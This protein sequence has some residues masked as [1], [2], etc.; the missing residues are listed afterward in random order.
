M[1]TA[2]LKIL[3]TT[4]ISVTNMIVVHATFEA[5]SLDVEGGTEN[6]SNPLEYTKFVDSY[7]IT[8]N[9]KDPWKIHSA[10]ISPSGAWAVMFSPEQA[11]GCGHASDANTEFFPV[12]LSGEISKGGGGSGKMP[13]FSVCGMLIA[14]FTLER[15]LE[16]VAVG[17]TSEFTVKDSSGSVIPNVQW[18]CYLQG[19]EV[20][21][22]TSGSGTITLPPTGTTEAGVYI[23]DAKPIQYSDLEKQS[24]DLKYVEIYSL[25]YERPSGTW[26]DINGDIYVLKG[27]SLSFKA[28][29][30]PT[31]GWPKD[32]PVWSGTSGASGTGETK[33]VSFGTTSTSTTDYKTVV[34]T[35]G[36]STKTANVIVFDA[37]IISVKFTSDHGV[38]KD[39]TDTCEDGGT[40]YTEPEWVKSSSKNNPISQTKGTKIA[41]KVTV[42][43]EPSGVKYNLTGSNTSS[44]FSFA[45][46]NITST[47]NNQESAIEANAELPNKVDI[48]TKS[49]NWKVTVE[50]IE[51]DLGNTGGHKVYVTYGIPAGSQATE[52]RI[53]KV[54][55]YAS[56]KTSLSDCGNAIFDELS[57]SFTYQGDT[58]WGPS[59]IWKLYL[60]GQQNTS[61]CPGLADFINKHFQILGLGAGIIKICYSTTGLPLD[62][63]TGGTYTEKVYTPTTVHASPWRYNST[64]KNDHTTS[65]YHDMFILNEELIHL[66]NKDDPTGQLNNVIIGINKECY[67]VRLY[68][69]KNEP[70]LIEIFYVN[71]K[72][73]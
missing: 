66:L 35:C 13:E 34:A 51:I 36:T 27:E 23:V 12:V 49:I 57:G 17:E 21:G 28:F 3:V 37:E 46:D 47:G 55:T 73:Y 32:K 15:T 44:Y 11:D 5:N 68:E 42:K 70:L 45:K 58:A 67:G 4:M 26:N 61:Q 43:V 60:G 19:T 20:P 2:A 71:Y 65:D 6:S 48:I 25:K 63:T 50:N 9:A 69:E 64:P 56:D 1:K 8:A 53:N 31:E 54:C 72:N 16:F 29:P 22:W 14:E 30:N 52:W 18:K 33:S 62:Q 38:M 39:K 10:V 41:L 59:P 40:L 7:Y 24:S